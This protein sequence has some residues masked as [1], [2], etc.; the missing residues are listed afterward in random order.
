VIITAFHVGLRFLNHFHG[1]WFINAELLKEHIVLGDEV[2]SLLQTIQ[3]E[4][5]SLS[6]D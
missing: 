6:W 2:I 1:V 5:N 3:R 4:D